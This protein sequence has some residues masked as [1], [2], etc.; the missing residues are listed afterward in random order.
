MNIKKIII[1]TPNP[2]HYTYGISCLNFS[3]EEVKYFYM[4]VLDALWIQVY[5]KIGINYTNFFGLFRQ[6]Y[7]ENNGWCYCEC[8]GAFPDNM[9]NTEKDIIFDVAYQLSKKYNVILEI[10]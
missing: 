1:V 7:D 6:G 10:E 5:Q 9:T 2:F 4:N 8:F 3:L